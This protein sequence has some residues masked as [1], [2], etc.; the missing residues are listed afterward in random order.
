MLMVNTFKLGGQIESI[1]RDPRE[2]EVPTI[3]P[4]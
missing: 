3:F 1:S 4:W 2:N